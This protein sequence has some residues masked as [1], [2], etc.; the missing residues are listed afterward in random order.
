ML[1]FRCIDIQLYH[2]LQHKMC[3]FR[4]VIFTDLTPLDQPSLKLTELK[5][6]GILMIFSHRHFNENAFGQQLK[7]ED[8]QVCGNALNHL[9]KKKQK[10]IKK[11]KKT[12]RVKKKRNINSVK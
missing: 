2:F 11:N 6:H 10:R 5:Q 9:Y 7:S 4:F 12:N 1:L 3:C 8:I